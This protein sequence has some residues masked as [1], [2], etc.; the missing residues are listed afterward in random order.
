MCV[1]VDS[2][3][4]ILLRQSSVDGGLDDS[5]HFSAGRA[6]KTRLPTPAPISRSSFDNPLVVLIK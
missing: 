2:I 6:K 4:R 5:L 3:S 1:D